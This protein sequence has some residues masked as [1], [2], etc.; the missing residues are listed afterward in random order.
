MRITS[1]PRAV[2]SPV[3]S[4]APSV[5]LPY[6][7]HDGSLTRVLERL[8]GCPLAVTVLA[9]DYR[10]LTLEE[11]KTLTNRRRLAPQMAWVRHVRLSV[12]GVAWVEAKSIFPVTSLVGDAKRLTHLGR[13]PIGYVL[14]KK[15]KKL[16]FVRQ[17][18]RVG[19]DFVRHSVYD[20]QG[21]TVV[22]SERFL[23]G[24]LQDLNC[25]E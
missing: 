13:T 21:R 16:P 5:L 19:T 18:G 3:L 20:W 6:L 23:V 24:M 12:R 8:A 4:D 22:V 17:F 11:R 9:E 10:S 1:S 25:I 2:L 15:Q 7:C 14:F